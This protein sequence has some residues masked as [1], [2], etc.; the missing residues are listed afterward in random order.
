M[1]QVIFSQQKT[2]NAN[3]PKENY[4]YKYQTFLINST[5]SEIN[6]VNVIIL[7]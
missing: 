7:L 3:L 1:L 5:N 6:L 4:Y 2:T